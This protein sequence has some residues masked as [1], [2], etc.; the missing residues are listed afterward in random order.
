MAN[1]KQAISPIVEAIRIAEEGSLGEIHVHLSKRWIEKDPMGRAVQIFF[2][3]GMAQTTH[4]NAI[5]IYANL[6]RKKFAVIGDVGI[7]KKVGQLGWEKWGEELRQNLF[8]TQSE[9]AI[10]LTVRLMGEALKKYFP[11]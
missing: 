11:S 1:G 5:L 7:Y 4:R 9:R 3:Y 8:F 10:A 6:R 2:A